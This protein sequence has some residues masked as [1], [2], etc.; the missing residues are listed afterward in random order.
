MWAVSLTDQLA[1]GGPAEVVLAQIS[2][3]SSSMAPVFVIPSRSA[4]RVDATWLTAMCAAIQGVV[5]EVT[6][7]VVESHRLEVDQ[8]LLDQFASWPSD[9]CTDPNYQ[10]I[11]GSVGGQHLLNHQASLA[12]Q[13][14]HTD[15]DRPASSPGS[16]RQRVCAGRPC[17]PT[18]RRSSSTAAV[19]FHRSRRVITF[20]HIDPGCD[21]SCSLGPDAVGVRSDLVANEHAASAPTRRR[22]SAG[23]SL[24]SGAPHL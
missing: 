6:R 15:P 16:H 12:C 2:S 1:L 24:T 3:P 11:A 20:R 9:S 8:D 4:T 14:L 18:Q 17:T 10:R 7:G 22:T 13:R 23:E 5:A 21:R 19:T